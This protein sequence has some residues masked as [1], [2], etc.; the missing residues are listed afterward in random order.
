MSDNMRW[1][2]GDTTPIEIA[3]D[4]AVVIEIGDLVALDAA[5]GTGDAAI[6]ASDQTWVG[7]SATQDAFHDVFLGVAMQRS[8]AGDTATIRVATT[9]VFE[10]V[11]ASATWLVGDLVGPDDNATPDALENQQVIKATNIGRAIARCVKA[12]ATVTTVLVAIE[13]VAMTGGPQAQ[14]A[15]S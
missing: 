12:A 10:F 5:I 15:S 7:L 13:S 14:A 3:V 11:C 8:R 6:P 4:S 1:R 9:G 2:Y